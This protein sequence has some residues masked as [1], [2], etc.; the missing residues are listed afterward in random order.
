[1]EPQPQKSNRIR[2]LALVILGLTIIGGSIFYSAWRSNQIIFIGVEKG[3]NS[4]LYRLDLFS[5]SLT[6][7]ASGH[8]SN[9]AWS[10]DGKRI[11]YVSSDGE[12]GSP[13]YHISV[14]DSDGGNIQQ[15]TW[16]QTRHYSPTWSPNGEQIAFIGSRDYEGG[17]PLAIF[18]INIDSSGIKQLTPYAYY[19]YPSWSPDGSK[20]AFYTFAPDGIYTVDVETAEI[21]RLTDQWNDMFPV[22]S[23]DGEYIAFASTRDD[24]NDHFDIYIMRNDGTGIR[25]LTS[26]P[27]HDRQPS[28]SADGKRIVFESN[29]GPEDWIY[30]IYI[31]NAD[32]SDQK[33]VTEKNGTSPAW[34]PR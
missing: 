8:F 33:R 15:L 31:M 11:A 25:R 17:S 27:A 34:R 22:W 9:P 28:W 10:P 29:R 18:L 23:P 12:H 32:G 20:I 1:M 26:D 16:G 5:G 13:P 14:M 21:H 6:L 2:I 7:L 24:P 4:G 19:N 3:S 30:H